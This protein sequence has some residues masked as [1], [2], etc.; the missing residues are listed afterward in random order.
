MLRHVLDLLSAAEGFERLKDG[1]LVGAELPVVVVLLGVVSPLQKVTRPSAAK[2]E[3]FFL[4]TVS[5]PSNKRREN[6]ARYRIRTLYSGTRGRIENLFAKRDLLYA[7]LRGHRQL[8]SGQ[9]FEMML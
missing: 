2:K 6:P 3:T 1:G 7:E 9:S 5:F 4:V 8:S